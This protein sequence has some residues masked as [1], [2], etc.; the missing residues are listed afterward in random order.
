MK[1]GGGGGVVVDVIKGP[2]FEFDSSCMLFCTIF[3]L[4]TLTQPW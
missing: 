1:V 2:L 3:M 4:I